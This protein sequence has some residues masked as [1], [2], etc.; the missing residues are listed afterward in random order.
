MGATIP[1]GAVA[2]APTTWRLSY[3]AGARV[4]TTFV[5]LESAHHLFDDAT[6][7]AHQ[8]T[9]SIAARFAEGRGSYVALGA[10]TTARVPTITLMWGVGT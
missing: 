6:G 2:S 9:L 7:L 10:S 1:I 4:G 3:A 8:H 5:S